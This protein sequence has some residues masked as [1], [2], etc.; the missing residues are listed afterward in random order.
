MTKYEGPEFPEAHE[1]DRG[2]DEEEEEG[3]SR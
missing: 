1:G 2:G 3:R